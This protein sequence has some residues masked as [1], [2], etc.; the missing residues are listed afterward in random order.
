MFRHFKKNEIKGKIESFGVA[1]DKMTSEFTHAHVCPIDTFGN[2]K[3][4][5]KF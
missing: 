2:F 4:S 5:R 1:N 3:W